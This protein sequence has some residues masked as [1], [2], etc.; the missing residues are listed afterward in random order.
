M[1]ERKILAKR[2]YSLKGKKKIQKE[3]GTVFVNNPNIIYTTNNINNTIYWMPDK[4]I[5]IVC[6]NPNYMHA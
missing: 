6:M 1:Q 3:I 5:N 2:A 4:P